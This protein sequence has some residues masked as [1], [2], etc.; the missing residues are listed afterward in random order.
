MTCVSNVAIQKKVRSRSFFC[1][2]AMDQPDRTRARDE[3]R[4]DSSAAKKRPLVAASQS[5]LVAAEEVVAK[6]GKRQRPA[7]RDRLARRPVPPRMRRTRPFRPGRQGRG[8]TLG[9]EPSL[10]D[11]RKYAP[12]V[13]DVQ[14][15]EIVDW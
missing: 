14:A 4:A 3:T 13:R 2:L 12:L 5:A 9:D 6:H 15:R 10:E 7:T 1:P 11:E 8:R